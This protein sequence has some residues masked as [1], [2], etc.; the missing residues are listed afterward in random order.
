[1][2]MSIRS[3]RYLLLWRKGLETW[4]HLL[5]STVKHSSFDRRVNKKYKTNS[6]ITDV[7][8][9]HNRYTE[10]ST[11]F[12]EK[13]NEIESYKQNQEWQKL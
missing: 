13:K 12:T 9:L 7:E 11:Y 4:W 1:M 3:N 5:K 6:Q 10:N 8:Y 2:L